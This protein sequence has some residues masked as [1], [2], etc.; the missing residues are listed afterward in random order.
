MSIKHPTSIAANH[1]GHW[2]ASLSPG[3][4]GVLALSRAAGKNLGKVFGKSV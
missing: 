3:P 2:T 4:P 1:G